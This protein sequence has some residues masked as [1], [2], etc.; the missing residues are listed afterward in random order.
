MMKCNSSLFVL[1]IEVRRDR[2]IIES[3]CG[4][5]CS[6]CDYKEKM[7]CKGCVNIDKPIWGDECPVKKCCEDKKLENCG[8]CNDFPCELLNQF[9]YDED[10]GDNGL[11]IEHCKKWCSLS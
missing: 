4:I 8:L 10:Q 9:A 3:R 5:R 1:I 7:N 2:M 11:R 6:D